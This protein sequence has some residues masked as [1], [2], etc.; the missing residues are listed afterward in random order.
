V[1]VA[2]PRRPRL[3]PAGRRRLWTYDGPP[4][5]DPARRRGQVRGDIV[6]RQVASQGLVSLCDRL[7]RSP[8]VAAVHAVAFPVKSDQEIVK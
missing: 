7:R 1:E 6:R 4:T 3:V 5:S 2:A 8:G